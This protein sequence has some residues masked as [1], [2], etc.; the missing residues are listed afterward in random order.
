MEYEQ[1]EHDRLAYLRGF[2]S[3]KFLQTEPLKRISTE[4]HLHV[5]QTVVIENVSYTLK[6]NRNGLYFDR[7]ITREG[8][9]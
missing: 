6:K 7:I 5:G 4:T 9:A 3:S 8:E 2:K 1:E